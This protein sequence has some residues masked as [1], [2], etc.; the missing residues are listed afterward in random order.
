MAASKAIPRERLTALQQL[1]DYLCEWLNFDVDTK[2]FVRE[3][4]D[5]DFV[6]PFFTEYQNDY[7]EATTDLE[8]IDCD[9]LMGW[10]RSTNAFEVPKYANSTIPNKTNWSVLD[11]GARF[12][13]RVL[14]FSWENGGE[15]THG[16]F[17]PDHDEESDL[18]F[19]QVWAILQYLQAE[20]EAANLEDW[21]VNSVVGT[22]ADIRL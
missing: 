4:L 14:R 20:W 11:H 13:V 12:L 9:E 15:W 5:S 2:H 18:E 8:E 10:C 17:S 22:F 16:R 7:L 21:D 6:K 19:Y 1:Y 3:I